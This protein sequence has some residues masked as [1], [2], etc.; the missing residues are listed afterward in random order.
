MQKFEWD[1]NKDRI[2]QKKHDIG[3][4]LASK[5]FC[6]K[7]V[8]VYPDFEHSQYEDRYIAI[9][10]VNDILFVSYTVRHGDTIRII[11]A[12]KATVIEEAFYYASNALS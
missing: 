10:R 6:D 2:N 8:V 4:K 3:F 11:S 5:V 1:P 12:R 7:N 9:G